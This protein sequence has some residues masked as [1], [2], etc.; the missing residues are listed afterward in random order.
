MVD[1]LGIKIPSTSPIF[2]AIVGVHVVAGLVCVVAGVVAM[3]SRK[4]RGQHPTFGTIYFWGLAA[5]FA[6]ATA[7]SVMRW[8]EDYHLFILGSLAFGAALLGRTARRGAWL[9]W[10]P[11]HI[12]SMGASYILLLTAFYVDNGKNLPI[13]KDLPT[14]A[15]WT[16]PAIVG[17][18]IIVR[19]LLSRPLMPTITR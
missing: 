9:H 3:L 5:V 18:P 12:C 11:A 17:L 14:I 15:Y 8:R 2:L 4:E 19:A 16:V 13:W 7:L 10:I 1:V 6:T